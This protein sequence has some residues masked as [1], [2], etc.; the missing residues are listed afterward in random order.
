MKKILTKEER[1]KWQ[2]VL[3]K[4]F[5]IVNNT[6]KGKLSPDLFEEVDAW[7]KEYIKSEQMKKAILEYA[8]LEK[9]MR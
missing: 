8:S 1:K 6:G 3:T 5:Q 2:S 4:Y 9:E 7:Y